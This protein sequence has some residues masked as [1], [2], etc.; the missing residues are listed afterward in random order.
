MPSV[1]QSGRCVADT[2]LVLTQ[3]TL[4]RCLVN[5]RQLSSECLQSE[6]ELWSSKSRSVTTPYF[7]LKHSE[8]YSTQSKLANHTAPAPSG[9]APVFDRRRPGVAAESVQLELRL[10]AHLGGETLVARD[11]EVCTARDLV[12]G[13]ALARFHVPQDAYIRSGRHACKPEF[14]VGGD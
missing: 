14:R 10:V 6:L 4:P 7:R 12:F 3:S 8:T 11:V 1:I 9:R 13:D 5:A 2:Y